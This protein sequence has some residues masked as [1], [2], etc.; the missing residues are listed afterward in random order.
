MA[1]LD[2]SFTAAIFVGYHASTTNPHGVRAHT[3]SSAHYAKVSLNGSPVTEGEFNAAYAGAFGVPVI[4]ASGDDAAVG[5]L[6]ARL[7]N[8]ETVE[9]KKS[10]SFH[11]ADSLTPA[12]AEA[13]IRAGV[14]AALASLHD[15]KPCVLKKPVALEITFKNYTPAEMLSYLRAVERIDSHT[16][17]FVGKDMAEVSDFVE[18]IRGYNP[19]LTP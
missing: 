3:F 8:I 14:Q 17:R 11:S 4:F 10:L 9:T 1:G 12:A 15:F 2:S 19:D 6:K 13:K 5:E 16:I 18:F 7:G